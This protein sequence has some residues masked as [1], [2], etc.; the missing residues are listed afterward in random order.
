M[1][2][3][4]T[5]TPHR[6]V[7]V[8]TLCPEQFSKWDS[9]RSLLLVK[10]VPFINSL[11]A[12]ETEHLLKNIT[13]REYDNGDY[14]VRQGDVGVEL[15]IIQKGSVKVVDSKQT[16][17]GDTGAVLVYILSFQYHSYITSCRI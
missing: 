7:A 17:G 10:N 4:H 8:A 9:L 13:M 14:I 16:S 12:K 3:H 11:G 5:T 15:F 1:T 6:S 2:P